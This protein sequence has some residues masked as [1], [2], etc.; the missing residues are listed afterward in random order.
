MQF[1]GPI[2]AIGT[3]KAGAIPRTGADP[4]CL[5]VEVRTPTTMGG[6]VG[7]EIA[8]D[9]IPDLVRKLTNFLNDPDALSNP[10]ILA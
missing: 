3:V 7:L 4:V 8:R 5:T 2:L 10:N 9:A 6:F 1:S